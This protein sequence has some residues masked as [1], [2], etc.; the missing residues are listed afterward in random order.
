MARVLRPYLVGR[1]II[2]WVARRD[3]LREPLSQ[4]G[5]PL[6]H[7]CITA[8]ERRGKYLVITLDTE[9]R[10][11]IH[12]GMTGSLSIATAPRP[13]APHEHLEIGLENGH[14]LRFCD[15]RRFGLVRILSSDKARGEPLPDIGPEPLSRSF[16]GP[17]L[18]AALRQRPGPIKVLLLDQEI[19]AGV[20][21]IYASEALFLARLHPGRP[22][23]SLTLEESKRL[24]LAIKQTLKRAIDSGIAA[25]AGATADPML[26]VTGDETHFSQDLSVYDRA[27]EPCL[28]CRT[29]IELVTM[30]G[31]STYFCPRC[32]PLRPEKKRVG[33]KK[34]RA[35][36]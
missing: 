35:N 1:T 24:V 21:N 7:T 10:L 17:V 19:V 29:P 6:L 27:T 12:L 25:L 16:S 26:P 8:L 15:P 34:S 11:L 23:D 5:K 31:R 28:L 9:A 4:D 2:T 36:A 14:S 13:A 30:G 32:Q 33:A 20:G 22:G 18:F 3:R